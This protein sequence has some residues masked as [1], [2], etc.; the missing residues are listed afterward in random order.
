M[1]KI[2]K[3]FMLSLCVIG[4]LA[5]NAYAKSYPDLQILVSMSN[6]FDKGGPVVQHV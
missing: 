2:V 1:K 4:L 3:S 5:T 6:Q